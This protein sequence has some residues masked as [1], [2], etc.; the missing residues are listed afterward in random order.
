MAGIETID[1][2]GQTLA[3]VVRAAFDVSE[4]TFVTDSDAPQQVGFIA[5]PRGGEIPRHDH[6]PV[7]RELVGT[8]EVLLVRR[9]SCELDLYDAGRTFVTTLRLDQGDLIALLAGGHGLRMLED[10][11]LVEVK[12]GPYVGIDEK[13]RF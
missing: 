7:D 12:Q 4:T 3:V 10:T 2:G 13:E 9:G 11:V 8:T 5:Y 6:R 1:A